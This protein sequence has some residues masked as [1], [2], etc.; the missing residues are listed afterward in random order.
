MAWKSPGKD[1]SERFACAQTLAA[2]SQQRLHTITAQA[3]LVFE[4]SQG[5]LVLFTS[6]AEQLA[7]KERLQLLVQLG[8]AGKLLTPDEART[9]EPALD[10]GLAFHS[11]VYFAQDEVGNCRQFAHFLKEKLLESGAAIHFSTPVTTLSG[12]TSPQLLTQS[13][14]AFAFDRVVVCTGATGANLIVPGFKHL[15]LASVWSTSVSAQTREPLNAPRSA[16]LDWQKQISISRMGARIRVSGGAALGHKDGRASV[17]TQKQL[18]QTLQSYFPGA[19]DFSRSM[20]IWQ[21]ASVFSPDALPLLGPTE[22]PSVW[23]NLAHGHNGWS[24]ACGAARVLADQISGRPTEID[25][26]KLNPCRFKS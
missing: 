21:G 5:Q 1:F 25:A 19:A 26:T 9:F 15:A 14:G 22:N 3:S 23:L 6:E 7:Q 4:Q 13:Q 17:R 20:Q 12:A 8:T 18:F 16:V 2:Y 10:P 11:A 24:M